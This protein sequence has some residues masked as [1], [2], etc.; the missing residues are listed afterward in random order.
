[1]GNLHLSQLKPEMT[2]M[3]YDLT[4]IAKLK[5]D[6]NVQVH[7]IADKYIVAALS[8][9]IRY[10]I[11]TIFERYSFNYSTTAPLTRYHFNFYF[12]LKR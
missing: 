9:H 1:M 11:D 5:R 4:F 3:V 12:T 8:G 7:T 10:Q 2:N 6:F